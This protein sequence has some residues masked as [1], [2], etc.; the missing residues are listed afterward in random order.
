MSAP[1]EKE[2]TATAHADAM[3]F[4]ARPA[5]SPPWELSPS[6]E[7]QVTFVSAGSTAAV[8]LTVRSS[9]SCTAFAGKEK[10]A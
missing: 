8:S 9:C 2:K 3:R 10:L 5:L 7:N 6:E 1:D 4:Y